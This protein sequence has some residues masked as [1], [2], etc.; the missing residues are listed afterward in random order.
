MVL[1]DILKQKQALADKLSQF[2]EQIAMQKQALADKLSRLEGQIVLESCKDVVVDKLKQ[3]LDQLDADTMK[4]F[5]DESNYIIAFRLHGEW[6]VEVNQRRVLKPG[7]RHNGNNGNCNFNG[8]K[9]VI[10]ED[11]KAKFGLSQTEF[12]SIRKLALALGI[13]KDDRHPDKTLKDIYPEVYESM[14]RQ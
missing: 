13:S 2:D 9:V 5:S 6:V 10:S 8:N 3:V 12:D 4:A 14:V 11:I 7:N 1:E